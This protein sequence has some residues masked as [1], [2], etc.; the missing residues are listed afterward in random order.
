MQADLK[1]VTK[2]LEDAKMRL[3]EVEKLQELD[4]GPEEEYFGFHGQ[5]FTL[6]TTEYNYEFC[7]FGKATQRSKSG[8]ND[9]HLGN[10]KHWE[11]VGNNRYGGMAFTNGGNCWGSPARH[12]LVNF[13]CGAASVA[14][15]V[16]EPSKCE[17][18][19]EF[20][21]PLACSPV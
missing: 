15:S 16:E 9:A 11:T 3:Q 12:L 6:S 18:V 20:E 7:P 19:M 17:Y 21:T 2:N 1:E 5:C 4:F 14:L 10:F 13:R 8:G